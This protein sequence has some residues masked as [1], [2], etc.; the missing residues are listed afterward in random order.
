MRKFGTQA[1]VFAMA[2]FALSACGQGG[3]T[4]LLTDAA[5]E[6]A[7][8]VVDKTP[9]EEELYINAATKSVIIKTAET[10]A[11][12]SGTCYVSTYP[13][14]YIQILYNGAALTL[15]NATAAGGAVGTCVQGRFNVSVNVSGFGG[16]GYTLVA[17]VVGVDS[18]GAAHVG[19][20]SSSF[21]LGKQ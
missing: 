15:V 20:L 8:N 3:N 7:E 13:N 5:S 18:A 4:S 19:A 12:I 9:K 6:S 14:H 10:R 1:C 16:G 21:Y 11:D 2:I 17:R